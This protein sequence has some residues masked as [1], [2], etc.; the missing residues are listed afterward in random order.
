MQKYLLVKKGQF[1]MSRLVH[2]DR[3]A[4]VIEIITLLKHVE[5]EKHLRMHNMTN[6]KAE[7]VQQ[8]EATLKSSPA[9]QEQ[10]SEAT[11]CTDEPKVDS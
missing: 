3:K 10:E 11:T 5:G 2:A 8:N 6:L 9:T 4:T 7:G 1:S